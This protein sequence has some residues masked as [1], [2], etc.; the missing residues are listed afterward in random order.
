MRD[1]SDQSMIVGIDLEPVNNARLNLISQFEHITTTLPV[2]VAGHWRLFRQKFIHPL[3]NANVV[4]VLHT[5]ISRLEII[6]YK[7]DLWL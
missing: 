2:R 1:V 3:E 4:E 5:D 6:D 7:S